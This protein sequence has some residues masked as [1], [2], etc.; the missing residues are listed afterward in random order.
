MSEHAK[1]KFDNVFTP[2]EPHPDDI[3]ASM[4]DPADVPAYSQNQMD[5]IVAEA[6]QEASAEALSTASDDANAA[7]AKTLISIEQ[8]IQRL[9]QFH[10]SI[11][12]ATHKEAVE[13]ALLIGRKLARELLD[14]EPKAEI[15][16][17]ILKLLGELGE[18]AAVPRINVRVHPKMLDDIKA[19]IGDMQSSSGFAGEINVLENA[20]IRQ[21]DCQIDWAEGGAQRDLQSL[22][23]N[24]EAA[25][26]RYLSAISDG[27]KI[28]E[29]PD[30]VEAASQIENPPAEAAS[31]EEAIEEVAE[32]SAPETP[33]AVMPVAEVSDEE[34]PTEET[35]GEETPAE[36]SSGTEEIPVVALAE[37]PEAGVAEIVSQ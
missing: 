28:S 14:R 19:R 34:T 32:T 9:G 7:A 8:E 2:G 21:T 15:E 29:T 1:F 24:V 22:E 25:I 11:V 27:E 5:E 31:A 4:I 26:G 17:L 37:P 3:T 16:A 10:D 36:E 30:L 35:P 18:I 20:T 13:L 33:A 6:R 12:Q 23:Q